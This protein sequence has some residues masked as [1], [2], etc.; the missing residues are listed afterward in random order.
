[1]ATTSKLTIDTVTDVRNDV[2]NRPYRLIYSPESWSADSKTGEINKIESE[3][4]F[5]Y[6]ESMFELLKPG[7]VINIVSN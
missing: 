6:D 7:V 4:H 2:H 1:M 5:C 3:K